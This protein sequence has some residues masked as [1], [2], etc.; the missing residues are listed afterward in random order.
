[1]WRM[2]ALRVGLFLVA[3]GTKDLAL[4]EFPITSLFSPRPDV[5]IQL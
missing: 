2:M 3:G 1:M 4:S 5:V